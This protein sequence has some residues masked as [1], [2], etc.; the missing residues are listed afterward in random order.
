M[1]R[2]TFINVIFWVIAWALMIPVF[3]LVALG[4]YFW[5]SGASF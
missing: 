3:I 5:I 4:L 2:R 1:R